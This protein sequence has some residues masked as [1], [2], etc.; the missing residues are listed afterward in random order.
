MYCVIT[1]VRKYLREAE[2]SEFSDAI[3]LLCVMSALKLSIV[4]VKGFANSLIICL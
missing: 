2:S 3:N 1:S 4:C